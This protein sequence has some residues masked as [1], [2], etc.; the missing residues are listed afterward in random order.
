MDYSDGRPPVEMRKT[1]LLPKFVV[2]QDRRAN[3]VISGA[4]SGR[5]LSGVFSTSGI[6]CIGIFQIKNQ[7]SKCSKSPMNSS[8]LLMLFL[9]VYS[10]KHTAHV[11]GGY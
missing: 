9:S 5:T 7:K 11:Y 8:Y 10:G 2:M 1:E 3:G 4:H 6:E